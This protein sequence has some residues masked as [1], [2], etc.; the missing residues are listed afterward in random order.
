MH[1]Y[2]YKA[3]FP[4]GQSKQA[5]KAQ[6][7]MAVMVVHP[8]K[9]LCTEMLLELKKLLGGHRKNRGLSPSQKGKTKLHLKSYEIRAGLQV[10]FGKKRQ[11]VLLMLSGYTLAPI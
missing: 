2:L 11:A 8:Q 9:D 4:C 6:Q 5:Q 7:N 3:D 10:R 1:E